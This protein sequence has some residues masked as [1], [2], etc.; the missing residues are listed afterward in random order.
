[1]KV[2]KFKIQVHKCEFFLENLFDVK[3]ICNKNT[4]KLIK[5]KLK[6]NL[7]RCTFF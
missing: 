2:V 5:K 7:Y 3:K 1:M 6:T 4:R